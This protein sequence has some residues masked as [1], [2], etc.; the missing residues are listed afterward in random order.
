MVLTPIQCNKII[1]CQRR[2]K[3][4]C[5]SGEPL[6]NFPQPLKYFFHPELLFE[7]VCLHRNKKFGKV[8]F[9]S[10][11]VLH[12]CFALFGT[13]CT[14]LKTLKTPMEKRYFW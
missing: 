3:S 12:I 4:C 14:M 10:R 11:P 7:E 13:I 8:V 1:L 5:L 6:G 9:F 2:R